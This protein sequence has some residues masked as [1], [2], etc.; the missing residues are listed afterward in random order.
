MLY[1]HF[2]Y[3]TLT[4][5]WS[6]VLEEQND[7]L[8]PYN[9]KSKYITRD[10][11]MELIIAKILATTTTAVVVPLMDTIMPMQRDNKNWAKNTTLDTMATSVPKPRNCSPYTCWPSS[12]ILN[13]K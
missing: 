13:C 5:L 10:A 3:F 12:V 11:Q 8:L 1:E 2:H 4:N 9:Y 7:L 6:T